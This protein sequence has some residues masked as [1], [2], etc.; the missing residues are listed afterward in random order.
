MDLIVLYL[1][2]AMIFLVIDA[3]GLKL[4]LRPLFERHV[5]E[6]LV[7]SFRLGPAI[8]FYL[9]YVAVLVALVSW[10]ELYGT[11]YSGVFLQAALLGAL[12]YGTYEFTN[13]ATLKPWHWSMVV[14]D[15]IWGISVT[16]TSVTAGLAVARMLF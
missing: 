7:P 9:F 13:L 14:T 5:G 12:A 6:L 8:G 2:T 11:T 4:L 16:A 15:M 10:P 1:A 3:I